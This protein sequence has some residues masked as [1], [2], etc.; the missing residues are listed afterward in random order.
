MF[1]GLL[2]LI[3]AG[4]LICW[5]SPNHL[6]RV[7]VRVM[8]GDGGLVE[9][10]VVS[11][12]CKHLDFWIQDRMIPFASFAESLP[13][14]V[15]DDRGTANFLFLEGCYAVQIGVSVERV[16]SVALMSTTNSIEVIVP[17]S[18]IGPLSTG[19]RGPTGLIV[20]SGRLGPTTEEGRADLWLSERKPGRCRVEG[21]NG[22]TLTGFPTTHSGYYDKE[23][24]Q[25]GAFVQFL[26]VP[27]GTGLDIFLRRGG[28]EQLSRVLLGA[29]EQGAGQ[30][31]QMALVVASAPGQ[32][33]WISEDDGGNTR[34]QLMGLAAYGLRLAD[35]R[36]ATKLPD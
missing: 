31:L 20:A 17:S 19:E 34:I 10:A 18:A 33:H 8:D 32:H 1:A 30:R 9:G 12:I 6:T 16:G 35:S 26:D 15:T 29:C 28:S 21:R 5:K 13:T 14:Q 2:I 11:S 24:P 4:G 27:V 22:H 23:P 36:A 3:L 7:E 25:D